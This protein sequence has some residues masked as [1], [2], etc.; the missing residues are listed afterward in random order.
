MYTLAAQ[1]LSL[2]ISLLMPRKDSWVRISW[3]WRSM[4]TREA[5]VME[6]SWG[7][8]S[9]KEVRRLDKEFRG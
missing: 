2:E 4:N 1:K 3:T 8:G 5:E 9:G 6:E 7:R